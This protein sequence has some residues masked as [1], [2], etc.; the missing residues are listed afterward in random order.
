MSD[1]SPHIAP[2]ETSTNLCS[3][4]ATY[5]YTTLALDSVGCDAFW[6]VAGQQPV[7]LAL[8]VECDTG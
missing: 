5:E 8:L 1:L 4:V 2:K 6:G 7:I 3:S